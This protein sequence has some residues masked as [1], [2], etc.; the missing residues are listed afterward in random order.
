MD[1]NSA[2]TIIVLDEIMLNRLI[3]QYRVDI[4]MLN[5]VKIPIK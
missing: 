1:F 5:A 4:F 3:K 2:K